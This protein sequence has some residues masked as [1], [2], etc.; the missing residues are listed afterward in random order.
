[1]SDQIWRHFCVIFQNQMSQNHAP[2]QLYFG[3][4]K[5][6]V[7]KE[8]GVIKYEVVYVEVKDNLVNT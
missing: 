4:I 8:D 3:D 2:K 1:M 5:T 7:A 6:A